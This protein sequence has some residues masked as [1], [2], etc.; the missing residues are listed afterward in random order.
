MHSLTPPHTSPH[1][2]H[3]LVQLR[4]NAS[5]GPRQALVPQAAVHL[6]Q[7]QQL[8]GD[9]TATQGQGPAQAGRKGGGPAVG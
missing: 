7:L 4:H 2:P 6:P 9:D 8:R 3:L 1:L 5:Q